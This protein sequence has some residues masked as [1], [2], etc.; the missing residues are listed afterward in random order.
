MSKGTPGIR[1]EELKRRFH[2]DQGHWP[3]LEEP[4]TIQEKVLWRKLNEDMSDAVR[5]ADKVAVRDYVRDT[6]GGGYLVEA[7]AIVEEAAALDFDILP[8]SF[9][10]KINHTSGTNLVVEDR[11]RMDV[12]SVRRYLGT[13]MRLRHGRRLGEHWYG[14]M[15]PRI[16]V[17]RLMR[18]QEYGI[19]LEF[20]FHVFHGK[21][22]FV[23][24]VSCRRLASE[25]LD[26]V[27]LPA[28]CSFVDGGPGRHTAY[29][30]DWEIAPFQERNSLPAYPALRRP[31]ARADEMRA[32]AEKLA[33]DWGYVRIDLCCPDDREVYFG[34]MTFA[35]NAGYFGFIPRSYDEYFGSLWDI[36]RRYVR[37][38]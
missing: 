34:E 30:L 9:I 23:Q 25:V 33:G 15:E 24:V 18:D 16:L 12:E 7:L 26:T 28:G 37:T 10:L 22:E 31:P 35:H 8:D 27:A 19:P 29:T 4:R 11:S 6:V 20:R 38:R 14:A 2:T 32:V 5:Q 21:A 3:N 13:L 1:I 36:R 17:E